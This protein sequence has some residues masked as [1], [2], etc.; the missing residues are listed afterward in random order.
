V[1]FFVR[2]SIGFLSLL[3]ITTLPLEDL[4]GED[5]NINTVIDPDFRVFWKFSIRILEF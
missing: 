4:N 3:T 1:W 5:N 2:I